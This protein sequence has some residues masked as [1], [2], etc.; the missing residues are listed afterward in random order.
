MRA[1]EDEAQR[2]DDALTTPDAPRYH[3]HLAAH[4]RALEPELWAWFD[5]VRLAD[6]RDDDAEVELLK[7]T[8]R[9][10]GG[11]HDELTGH[12]TLIAGRLGL[13]EPVVLYQQ[14]HD[15]ERN[16]RVFR[17][18]GRIHVVFVGDLLDLFEPA[19]QRVVLAHELAHIAL[20]GLAEGEFATLDHLVH[21]LALEAPTNAALTESA[22]RLRLRTEVWADAVAVSVLG[23]PR[24][25]ISTIV[26]TVTGL[27][28]VDPDAYL[29]QA[30][31]ILERDPGSSR[32]LTHP[33]LHI[34]VACLAAADLDHVE[35]LVDEL[36][37]GPDDLDRIDLLGQVRLLALVRRV[38]AGAHPLLPSD[39][40]I[41]AHVRHLASVTELGRVRPIDDAELVT[42][43][44]SIR[45]LAAAQL[46]DLAFVP[47]EGDGL[48]ELRVLSHEA[49]RIGV[50]A[51]FDKIVAKASDRTVAQARRLRTD[52]GDPS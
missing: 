9:L 28:N 13:S 34:R 29:K 21:R 30:R 23:D 5:D 19:E 45:H 8:Y 40:A 31:Q 26:K 27:R 1:V 20:W 35:D 3:R 47:R 14:L 7:T 41:D 11:V 15:E 17:L 48:G 52:G 51:E 10:D 44:P 39:D 46:V 32:Q 49:E 16:A 36:I 50:A 33:E 25:V 18:N 42:V 4:L 12:G 37:G 6:R 22:R 43:T 24:P 38:L 2:S